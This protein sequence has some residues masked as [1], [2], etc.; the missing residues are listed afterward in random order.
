M[1][2]LI[3]CFDG[4]WNSLSNPKELTNVV[5]IANTVSL[6][7][8]H[9]IDQVCYYNS[10]VG[11]GGPIDRFIGGVFGAGLRSNVQ[12]GLAFLTLN[13][14][15]K[16]GANDP[17]EIYLF[18]F[19]RGA[20]TARALAGV[21]G[22]AGIPVNISQSE[23]H[24]DF[25][26]RLAKLE[27]DNRGRKRTSP[28]YKRNKEEIKLLRDALADENVTLYHP[29]DINIVCVGV[30]DTVGAYGVPM[31]FGLSAI[32]NI[33]TYW[34]RGFHSRQ[35]GDSVKVAL[36]AMAIDEMRRPFYPT[37]WMEKLKREADEDESK[38][39]P[40]ATS[41]APVKA[42]V[43]EQMWFVGVHSN[44]GGGYEQSGLSDLA[45]AWMISRVKANTALAFDD[46]ELLAEIWPCPASTLYRSGRAAPI[47]RFR[48][49]LP[50]P[51]DTLMARVWEGLNIALGRRRRSRRRMN[52]ELHWS[53][54]QRL[55]WENALVDKRG[56]QKYVPGNLK[57][58]S[59]LKYS[60]PSDLELMLVGRD[61]DWM[62]RC[63]MEDKGLPCRCVELEVLTERKGGGASRQAA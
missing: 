23:K 10:G 17:D 20:Y 53:V 46:S 55:D 40:A 28:I 56:P 47:G 8:P 24:W 3:L 5:K 37:F 31:G 49:I 57:T 26:R 63:P 29:K 14:Q 22:V 45:L 25:Y 33:F 35:V 7:D 39:D 12:R 21:L 60:E 42:Q 43:V 41:P 50:R 1:K 9:G 52:E 36:H 27:A 34:T 48:S 59:T 4:T 11:S 16:P 44:V 61:R 51:A 13:Y 18:G 15:N 6:R 2:R 54:K 30:F 62:A 32:S 19:S 38:E 58:K